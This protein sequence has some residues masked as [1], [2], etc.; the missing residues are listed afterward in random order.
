MTVVFLSYPSWVAWASY[1]ADAFRCAAA[2]AAKCPAARQLGGRS[3]PLAYA[4]GVR[5]SKVHWTCSFAALGAANRASPP[6]FLDAF[7]LADAR[8]RREFPAAAAPAS[9]PGRDRKPMPGAALAMAS[10]SIHSAMVM[11]PISPHSL[12]SPASSASSR[13]ELPICLIRRRRISRSPPG[14][15]ADS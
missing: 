2:T 14:R 15:H 13:L 12:A 3:R 1:Q 9:C 10:L 6:A 5:R 11:T 4:Q 7:A 8:R